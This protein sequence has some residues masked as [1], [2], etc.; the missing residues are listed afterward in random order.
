VKGVA[1]N[2][3]LIGREDMPAEVAY[4]IVKKIAENFDRYIL[5]AKAMAMGKA[6]EMGK[7]V[8]FAYHPGAVKYYQER[9]WI[10]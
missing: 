5:V 7:D 8:G 4:G 10:K 2:C 3:I 1:S 9:G 6:I